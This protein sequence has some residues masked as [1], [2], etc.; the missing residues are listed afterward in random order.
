MDIATIIGV[1][2]SIVVIG[3]VMVLDGGSPAELFSHTAPILLTLVGSLLAA[4][5][6]QEMATLTSLPKLF[7]L[8]FMGIKID[9]QKAIDELTTMA[10]KA[11]R[12]G[13][14]A[15]ESDAKGIE[16]DFMRKGVMM[17]VDGVDPSQV[18]AIMETEI[19]QMHERHQKGIDLLEGAGGFA[20]TFGIIGTVMGM[21]VILKQLD[22]PATLGKA[23]AS[24]FLATLWGLLS[25]NVVYMPVAGKLA[26][27]DAKEKAYRHMITEGVLALQAGENPR[28]IRDKLSA[29][30]PPKARK[31]EEE[32]GK[33][34][35]A[36]ANA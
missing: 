11:R 12:E 8:A 7:M 33:A 18:K 22:E 4:A 13:L 9:S 24:A 23:I 21:I 36:G 14:L 15:L 10:D 27:N 19:K 17:V 28:I 29:Y 16:D 31:S 25:S 1:V 20:P 34:Q 32:A 3:V 30:L 6:T 5:S 2:G 35:R 26:V